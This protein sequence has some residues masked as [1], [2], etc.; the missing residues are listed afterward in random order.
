MNMS[1]RA[2]DELFP[3][4]IGLSKHLGYIKVYTLQIKISHE[5]L[6]IGI[7]MA[8]IFRSRQN[9]LSNHTNFISVRSK[10]E[11]LEVLKVRRISQI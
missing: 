5:R 3:R 8:A 6:K 7:N 10:F 2:S 4:K 9:S 1:I 11:E